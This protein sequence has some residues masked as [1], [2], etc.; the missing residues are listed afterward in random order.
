MYVEIA[1]LLVILT[2]TLTGLSVGRHFDPGPVGSSTGATVGGVLGA[3]VGY[4]AGGVI[5]RGLLQAFGRVER[6]VDRLPGAHL[7]TG[8]LGAVVGGAGGVLVVGPFLLLVPAP[9]LYLVATLAV[10]SAATL[11]ARI[12]VRKT[13]ELLAMAGLSSRPLVRSAPYQA[14][15]GFIVDTSAVMDN[16]L[17]GLVRAGFL[18]QELLI[19]R[20]V[21]DELHGFADTRE[22]SQARRARRG[23]EMLDALKRE[24]SAR[25]RVL[26][27]EVPELAEVDAKLVA[28]ARRLQLRLLTCD[29]NL[30]RV[31]QLQDVPV[32]N[33]RRLAADL[34][35]EHVPGDVLTVELVR[36]GKEPGQGVGFLDDGSMVVVNEAAHLVGR[37]V[38]VEVTTTIPTS[39]GRL[40]FARLVGEPH[41]EE[42]E[43]RQLVAGSDR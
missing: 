16:Q 24:G 26:D 11:G 17:P 38:E 21:L 39:V 2:C 12:G 29:V 13:E 25:I 22:G 9:P 32:L 18:D 30:Q 36:E 27:D 34:R 3:L 42:A 14:A 35:P 1:R 23:L 40:L 41:L 20:F 43:R 7:F 19:P 15:D 8:S 28:L 10:W 4:V 33:L 5:G 37:D 31:A 6:R